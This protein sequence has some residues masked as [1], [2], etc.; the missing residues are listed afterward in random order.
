MKT[1]SNKASIRPDSQDL[2]S[3]RWQL[4]V[5]LKNAS[6]K[7]RA[8]LA[9]STIGHFNPFLAEIC[10]QGHLRNFDMPARAEQP[11]LLM[12][13]ARVTYLLLMD[14]HMTGENNDGNF[15]Q[16]IFHMV[17]SQKDRQE[18]CTV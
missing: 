13:K 3:A 14:L 7:N 15:L 12:K 10:L 11:N 4:C 6:Q 17:H 2:K 1:K 9:K 18:L 8:I 5:L 16:R